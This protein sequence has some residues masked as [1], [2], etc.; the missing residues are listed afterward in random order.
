MVRDYDSTIWGLV[1]AALTSGDP[2]NIRV[3][4]GFAV[5][6]LIYILRNNALMWL[7]EYGQVI[8]EL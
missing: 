1:R 8:F 2:T 3:V 5:W 4:V 7:T 6:M